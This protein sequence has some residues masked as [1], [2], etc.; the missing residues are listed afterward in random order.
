MTQKQI[1]G[2]DWLQNIKDNFDDLYAATLTTPPA[3]DAEALAKTETD[4]AVTPGNLAALGST[5]TFAGLVELAT[6]A[7]AITGTDTARAITPKD[8]A[9]VLAASVKRGVHTVTGGEATANAAAIATGLAAAT[10]FIVQVYRAGVNVMADAVVTLAG[11]TLTI[12]DGAST[13]N[14]TAGDVINWN[15][16]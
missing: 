9:D 16:F 10:G 15:V 2:G 4:R 7:E 11:G 8:L 12:A 13:Y 6:S 3:S 14:M 5:A 1:D